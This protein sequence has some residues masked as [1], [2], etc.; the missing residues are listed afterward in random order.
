MNISPHTDPNKEDETTQLVAS[1]LVKHQIKTV[2]P[3]GL[4]C[5]NSKIRNTVA[6]T[7]STIAGKITTTHTFVL[8]LYEE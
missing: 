2:L 1:D 3:K 4:Y 6:Y 8:E 7:I 5:N